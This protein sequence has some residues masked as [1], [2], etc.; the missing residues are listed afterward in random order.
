[1]DVNGRLNEILK[2]NVNNNEC[3]KTNGSFASSYSTLISYHTKTPQFYDEIKLLLP[4]NLNEKYHLL[5]K[6]FHIS[7]TNASNTSLTSV[8]FENETSSQLSNNNNNTENNV[9]TLVGYAWLPLYKKGRILVHNQKLNLPI[10]Q[11]LPNQYLSIDSAN[12]TTSNVAESI[13]QIKWVDNMKPL[14]KLN[15]ILNSCVHTY[16]KKKRFIFYF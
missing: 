11:T 5:F 14:F 1:M 13:S 10:A 7:C 15:C 2:A 6:F 4:L 16:V 12:S 9:E 8:N 3:D